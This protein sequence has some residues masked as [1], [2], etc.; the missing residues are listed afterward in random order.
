MI[1][2]GQQDAAPRGRELP[3]VFTGMES[4]CALPGAREEPP[5]T[6][7]FAVRFVLGF[8]VLAGAFEASRGTAFERVLV[9]GVILKPTAAVLA[10]LAPGAHAQLFGRTLVLG[11][12]AAL[13][14]TRGCEGI[15]LFL[16]LVAAV[17][18]FPALWKAR[19][20]GL[21][22]GSL[23]AYVLSVLRLIVLCLT[24]RYSPALWEALHGLVLP[25]GPIALLT[26]YFARWS[27]AAAAAA[28][29][30][31]AHAA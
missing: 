24:L 25:L 2:T 3:A 8:A 6:W 12:G 28:G 19:L 17:L 22:V 16:L 7:R 11:G 9:E 30:P 5:M 20:R 14:V 10:L 15:E 4:G 31:V 26:I 27:A 21:L 13:R 29:R 18:A 1:L 23:L